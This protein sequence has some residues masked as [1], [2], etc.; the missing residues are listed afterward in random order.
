MNNIR[1]LNI[2]DKDQESNAKI[3]IQKYFKKSLLIPFFGSGFTKG[4]RN[5]KGTVPDSSKLVES[6]K[7]LIIENQN[8]TDDDKAAILNIKDLKEA[9]TF[10]FDE[11]YV[12]N[13]KAKSLLVN[14]F[15]K[16]YFVK[17]HPWDIKSSLISKDWP[18][19]FTFNIDDAIESINTKYTIITP[20]K[21]VSREFISSNQCLFKIH[22]DINEFAIDSEKAELIFTSK[23]YMRSLQ[24]N[25]AIL[26]FLKEEAQTACF[27]FIGASLD[28]EVDL[29][30]A[31]IDSAFEKSIY[32]KVGAKIDVRDQKKLKEYGINTV[33]LFDSYSIMYKW[34]FDTLENLT[35]IPNYIEEKIITDE[36]TTETAKN[37][38]SNGGPLL[39]N[40]NN[41]LSRQLICSLT[42]PI[43]DEIA[44]AKKIIRNHQFLFV[45]GKRF[46]GKTLFLHQ[47][48]NN[49][50]EF[51]IKFSSTLDSLNNL[52]FR[53]ISRT[54]NTLYIFDSNSLTTEAF[55]K[56]VKISIPLSNKIVIC[57]SKGDAEKFRAGLNDRNIDYRELQ[58]SDKLSKVEAETFNHNLNLLGLPKYQS[59]NLLSF[60]YKYFKNFKDDLHLNH[61]EL[62]SKTISIE[63]YPLFVLM[64]S[65]GKVK[66]N[67]ILE[68]V[69]NLDFN[70]FFSHYG[71]LFEFEETNNEKMLICNAPAWLLN[72]IRPFI[73]KNESQAIDML[74]NIITIL[75]RF[76]FT[77]TANDLFRFD[78]LNELHVGKSS[79]FFIIGIYEKIQSIY[80]NHQNM[81]DRSHYWLQRSKAEL[82]CAEP[83]NNYLKSGIMHAKKVREDHSNSKNK[84]YFSATLTLTNLYAKQYM[85]H[86]KNLKGNKEI[87][88]NES[89]I[90]KNFIKYCGESIDNLQHNE[91]HVREL[92]SI[93]DTVS[94]VNHLKQCNNPELLVL[95]ETINSILLFFK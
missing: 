33:F 66:S 11:S 28:F 86:Q 39:I 1:I 17:A 63:M 22:G 76:G 78:K 67:L 34:I 88:S 20:N 43:R 54:E 45:T 82:I 36:L 75:N 65:I 60:A 59:E 64:A 38:I 31:G 84:T 90:L 24:S 7:N 6:I 3:E 29:L 89:E 4:A 48:I 40:G 23:Q 41:E 68:L 49:S 73:Q 74:V 8:L 56:L 80:S 79:R 37:L 5:S 95:K 32:V 50:I 9:F 87:L 58:L 13:Q 69:P 91:R 26:Q 92:K 53:D 44:E 83:D 30:H 14:F 10:L 47:L 57:S 70:A 18:H 61:L 2:S 42:F 27:L 12:S 77:S 62:F 51:N 71:R 94:T 93:K 16:V 55:E 52:I 35:R 72:D 46:S 15:S 85:F 21:N 25:A 19:I 81:R